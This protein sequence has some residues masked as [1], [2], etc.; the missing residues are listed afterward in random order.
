MGNAAY[1]G[2][3]FRSVSGPFPGI[4]LLRE[5]NEINEQISLS[6]KELAV[7]EAVTGTLLSCK[8]CIL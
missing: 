6:I 8:T 7:L 3:P 2:C 1:I 5:M 4:N